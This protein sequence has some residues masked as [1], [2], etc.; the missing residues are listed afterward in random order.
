MRTIIV[1]WS[2]GF[3]SSRL[4]RISVIPTVTSALLRS[5]LTAHCSLH[6]PPLYN[7]FRSSIY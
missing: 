1:I 5:R 7:L 6:L 4:P 3:D 2:I